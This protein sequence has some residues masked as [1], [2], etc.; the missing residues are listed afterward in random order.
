M[1]TRLGEACTTES[2]SGPDASPCW[3]DFTTSLCLD[4][5]NSLACTSMAVLGLALRVRA[6]SGHLE[7]KA[8]FPHLTLVSLM[9]V[10]LSRTISADS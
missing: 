7:V 9:A 4:V 2:T 6:G 5:R 10:S 1:L 8:L 3:E